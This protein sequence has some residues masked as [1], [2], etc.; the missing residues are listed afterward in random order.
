[1]PWRDELD[2]EIFRCI[3][4]VTRCVSA[5]KMEEQTGVHETDLLV[6]IQYLGGE[7]FKDRWGVN[8]G[9]RTNPNVRCFWVQP[10]G[11]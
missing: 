4:F 11:K 9:F 1:M 6:S 10:K 5:R 3:S 2:T 7:V 8:G